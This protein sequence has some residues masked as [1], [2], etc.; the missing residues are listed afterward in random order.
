MF[1][2]GGYNIK[3]AAEKNTTKEKKEKKEE[4]KKMD[5]KKRQKLRN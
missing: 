4:P 2:S 5:L 3:K 1:R